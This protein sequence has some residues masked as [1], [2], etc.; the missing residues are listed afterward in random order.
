MFWSKK[1]KPLEQRIVVR[2]GYPSVLT[3]KFSENHLIG[4]EF[5]PINF[6]L[7][8]DV[9]V[10]FEFINPQDPEV[11]Y[12]IISPI[13]KD[14]VHKLVAMDFPSLNALL[15]N[16]QQINAKLLT[17]VEYQC[18]PLGVNIKHIEFKNI[19][20]PKEIQ[21]KM[22]EIMMAERDARLK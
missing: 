12:S 8:I 1:K 20:P 6:D 4:P 15:V 3:S 2:A 13:I 9:E 14:V 16:R 10:V 19:T 22:V 18:K 11:N 17:E 7:H 5:V 21:D